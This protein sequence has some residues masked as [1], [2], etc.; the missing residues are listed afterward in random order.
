M[1]WGNKKLTKVYESE[2]AFLRAENT[3]LKDRLLALI[4]DSFVN[5]KSMQIAETVPAPSGVDLMGRLQ[6]MEAIT[7]DEK[8]QKKLAETQIKQLFGT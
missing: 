2:I 1:F 4:G 7:E 3:Q 8:R 5:Y 6:S